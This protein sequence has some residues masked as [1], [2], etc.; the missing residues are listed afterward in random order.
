MLELHIDFD[1][2]SKMWRSNKMSIG[3]GSFKYIC[4]AVRKDGGKCKNKPLKGHHYCYLHVNK[5]LQ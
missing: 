2:A 5:K 3:S 4:G 1:Y